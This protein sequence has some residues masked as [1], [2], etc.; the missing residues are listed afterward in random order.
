MKILSVGRAVE[1]KGFDL[2][3]TALAAL[4]ADLHWRWTHIGGGQLK[5]ALAQQADDAG[6]SDRVDW[7]GARAQADVFEAYRGSDLFVLP[8]RIAGDGD[9]DGLPNVLMEAQSQGLACLATAVAGIPEV[10]DD[11]ETGRLVPPDDAPALSEALANSSRRRRSVPGSA[12]RVRHG[13]GAG[14]ITR[15]VS[16]SCSS[17]FTRRRGARSGPR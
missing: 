1:K 3:I 13:S 8:S 2:M 17:G 10:I 9:R 16:I 5:K 4:P 11:G 7:L 14:S 6:I 15:P 12:P